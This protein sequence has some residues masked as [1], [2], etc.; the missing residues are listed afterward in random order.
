MDCL[1]TAQG[2]MT[3][4]EKFTQLPSGSYQETCGSSYRPC[5][6][7]GKIL[8]CFCKPTNELEIKR[9][10]TTLDITSCKKD[11]DIMNDNGRLFC[12]LKPQPRGICPDEVKAFG[13]Q[14]CLDSG[15][16]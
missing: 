6:F 12:E 7:D 16:E 10:D 9:V 4:K 14:A 2:Q 11:A 8:S 13:Q 3:C 1:Y 5:T 15:Y